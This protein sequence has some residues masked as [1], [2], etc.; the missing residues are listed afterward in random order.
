MELA[1]FTG[2][3]PAAEPAPAPAEASQS[4]PA[5][6]DGAA[7][8]QLTPYQKRKERERELAKVAADRKAKREAA[9]PGKG[10]KAKA[11]AEPA[12][13]AEETTEEWDEAQRAREAGGFWRLT[14]RIVSLCMWPF[15]Y[16]L[17]PLTDKECAEDVALL[18]P[19]ASRHK[20]LEVMVRYAA[21]P[22]LLVERVATKTKKR[23]PPKDAP[24]P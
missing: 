19:L 5:P 20:W 1:E 13:P 24:K 10:G 15:G 21:L 23:E 16:R 7:P 3:A 22:Y 18:A 6:S 4:S 14:L 9:K 17:D 11:G 2:A 12:Q 8:A